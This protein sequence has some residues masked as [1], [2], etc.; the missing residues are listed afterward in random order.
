VVN[1]HDIIHYHYQHVHTAVREQHEVMKIRG[2]ASRN[3]VIT[4]TTT[5]T[6][7]IINNNNHHRPDN[8]LA[9][10][11]RYPKALL[12]MSGASHHHNPPTI[13]IQEIGSTLCHILLKGE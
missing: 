9:D 3:T 11:I 1:N 12:N 5:T 13:V 6:T 8:L 10:A 7:T 2:L 4:T